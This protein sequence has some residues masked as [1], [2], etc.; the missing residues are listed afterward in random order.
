MAGGGNR[1]DSIS[2]RRPKP[3][4]TVDLNS[5]VGELGVHL[6]FARDTFASLIRQTLATGVCTIDVFPFNDDL[7][8]S[9]V[10]DWDER[11]IVCRWVTD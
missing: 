11:A 7:H 1:H 6:V 5:A 4:I 9:I 2:Y 10:S 3:T 8:R